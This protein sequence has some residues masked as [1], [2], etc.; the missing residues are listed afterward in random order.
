MGWNT[1]QW[2]GAGAW[3]SGIGTLSA[4]G[5]AY[6][7]NSEQRN[8]HRIETEALEIRHQTQLETEKRH[9]GEQLEAQERQHGLQLSAV[10]AELDEGQ[11]RH[12]AQLRE[13]RNLRQIEA[14]T[15]LLDRITTLIVAISRLRMDLTTIILARQGTPDDALEERVHAIKVKLHGWPDEFMDIPYRMTAG[16]SATRMYLTDTSATLAETLKALEEACSTL[17]AEAPAT[18]SKVVH[19]GSDS[20]SDLDQAANPVLNALTDAVH[21][22]SDELKCPFASESFSELFEQFRK[23]GDEK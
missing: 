12:N 22:A 14:I 23:A 16:F 4:V 19:H 11:R 2:A 7:Q 1:D 21:V 3:L 17:A 13:Q 5:F 6:W 15:D 8:R 9:H 20:L 10:R 18:V